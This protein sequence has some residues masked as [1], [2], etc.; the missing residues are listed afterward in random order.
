MILVC[1]R[2]G[3]P[4]VRVVESMLQTIIVCRKCGFNTDLSDGVGGV[5]I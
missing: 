5:V 2:C 1:N 4:D 3:S